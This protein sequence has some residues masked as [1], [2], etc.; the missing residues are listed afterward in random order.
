MHGKGLH[1]WEDGRKYQGDYYNDKK[2]G[3][4]RYYW[5]DGKMFQGTWVNGKR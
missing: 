2:H 1:I 4:G 3:N 5:P